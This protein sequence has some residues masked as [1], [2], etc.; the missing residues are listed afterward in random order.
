MDISNEV[1][2]I[3]PAYVYEEWFD[4]HPLQNQ[5]FSRS[6]ALTELS[7]KMC[8]MMRLLLAHTGALKDRMKVG[9]KGMGDFAVDKNQTIPSIHIWVWVDKVKSKLHL[10]CP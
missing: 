3:Y 8:P 1:D 6:T 2:F 5:I 7:E 9:W 4:F 10:K